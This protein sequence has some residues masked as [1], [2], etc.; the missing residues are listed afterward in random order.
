[1][2]GDT[3]NADTV[4]RFRC[5]DAGDMRAVSAFV[6]WSV[7]ALDEIAASWHCRRIAKIPAVDVVNVAVSVIVNAVASNFIEILPEL[8]VEFGVLSV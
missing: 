7:V 4:I 6:I 8:R 2:P 3:G 5:D 1:M